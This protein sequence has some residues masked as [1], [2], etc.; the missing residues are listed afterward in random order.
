MSNGEEKQTIMPTKSTS[1]CRVSRFWSI[2]LMGVIF[3]IVWMAR[4]SRFSLLLREKETRIEEHLVHIYQ[5]E[6]NHSIAMNLQ[7]LRFSEQHERQKAD[8]QARIQQL[9]AD[10]SK[11]MRDRE[12]RFS[13]HHEKK[14]SDFKARIQE[15]EL[16]HSI[17]MRHQDSL[18]S[19][20]K[21]D[22]QA[23]IQ[24]LEADHSKAMRDRESRF[25]K[26]HETQKADYQARIHQLEADHSK[27]MRDRDADHSQAMRHQDSLFSQQKADCQAR[28]QQLEAD[29]G[30][31]YEA[32]AK[33][34]YLDVLDFLKFPT[35]RKLLGEIELSRILK[36]LGAIISKE[37]GTASDRYG[38]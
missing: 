25:S 4:E 21:A 15:L 38:G 37:G 19:Q 29:R 23:R 3:M 27:A 35:S 18:V 28:I 33:D 9:A 31:M 26:E 7:D 30:I 32:C 36:K 13:Q 11:A 16:N 24:Q 10:H 5:L 12:S 2:A 17:A 6:L 20:Q 1:T 8:Y 34:P 14:K 22:Y